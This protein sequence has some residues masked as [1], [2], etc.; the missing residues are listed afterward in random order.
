MNVL[1]VTV[2]SLRADRIRSSVMPA[3][4]SFS[5]D[6]IV[7]EQCIANGPSTPA[8][9]PTIHASQYAASVEGFGIPPRAASSGPLTLAETLHDAGYATAGYT[10]NQFASGAYNYD[11]GFEELY[12]A[13]GLSESS[14]L[15]GF[16]QSNLDKDGRLFRTIERVYN[17][18]DPILTAA[19][20]NSTEHERAASLNDRALDWID[21]QDGDWFAWLHYMDTHHPYEAPA[22]YQERY[23][24]EALSP[25]ACR[26]LSR[27]GTHHPD[28]MTESEWETIRGLYDAECAYVD[29]QFDALRSALDDRGVLDETVV[30]LTADHGELVGEHGHA[31][32]P[33]AFWESIIRVP[34][35]VDHPS[36]DAASVPGQVRLID[37]APTITDTLGLDPD[38]AWEGA[39]ALELVDSEIGDREWAFGGVG[40]SLEYDIGFARRADG[41]KLLRHMDDVELCFNVADTPAEQAADDRS[42]E[43][44][45][46]DALVDALDAHMSRMDE[47]RRGK[48]SGIGEDEEMVEEH[49]KDLGYME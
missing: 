1:L 12:D 42:G 4:R 32:H 10:D 30:V 20:G 45:A 35:V 44:P 36:R 15:K 49:L 2:D 17:A 23:L 48:T 47:L 39:S 22:S 29:A 13:G 26:R 21:E 41:W 6:A 19:T 3:T 46:Y 40:R 27:K 9:F 18:V 11:R 37:L 5:D 14:R 33:P 8:S 38:P 25:A 43:A 34:L 24:D 31:G 16:V 7:F 28:E